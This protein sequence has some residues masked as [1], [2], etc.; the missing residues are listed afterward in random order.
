MLFRCSFIFMLWILFSC[1]CVFPFFQCGG[2]GHLS[3]TCM[4]LT[5]TS[6]SSAGRD[7]VDGSLLTTDD[8]HAQQVE[9]DVSDL[10]SSCNHE[11]SV[12]GASN[13]V[14]GH[15]K[16]SLNFWVEALDASDFVLDM[17]RRGYTLTCAQYSSQ[18]FLS[19]FP[20]FTFQRYCIEG[21]LTK[22]N[23]VT[24][25]KQLIVSKLFWSTRVTPERWQQYINQLTKVLQEVIWQE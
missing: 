5:D 14:K 17:I 15:F 11:F 9:Y 18:C 24:N 2:F 13:G 10:L 7:W 3:L 23:Q 4:K 22:L 16:S 19:T 21:K 25:R 20:R 12:K 6:K 8:A 1:C